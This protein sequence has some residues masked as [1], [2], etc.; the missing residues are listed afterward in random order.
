LL[1]EKTKKEA[2]KF[3]KNIKKQLK[4]IKQL[5]KNTKEISVLL[6]TVQYSPVQYSPG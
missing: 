5:K 4:I 3:P 1:K 2:K 6:W